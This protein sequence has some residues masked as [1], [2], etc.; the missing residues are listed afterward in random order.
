MNVTPTVGEGMLYLWVHFNLTASLFK[1][2][3]SLKLRLHDVS[4]GKPGGQVTCS[5]LLAACKRVYLAKIKSKSASNFWQ[6]DVY[7]RQVTWSR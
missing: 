6:V 1:A 4:R 2:E 7:T 5:K 3:V